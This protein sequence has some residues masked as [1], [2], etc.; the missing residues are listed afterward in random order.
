MT[1]QGG[2]RHVVLR[3]RFDTARLLPGLPAV[4]IAAAQDTRIRKP[5]GGALPVG[6][7]ALDL[8][9]AVLFSF[10]SNP[11]TYRR[12]D[13]VYRVDAHHY[14]SLASQSPLAGHPLFYRLAGIAAATARHLLGLLIHESID[15]GFA[16]SIDGLIGQSWHRPWQW[17][18]N[19]DIVDIGEYMKVAGIPAR[20][21]GDLDAELVI[22][23]WQARRTS[24]LIAPTPQLKAFSES[25]LSWSVLVALE[26]MR[27]PVPPPPVPQRD[28]AAYFESIWSRMVEEGSTGEL[29]RVLSRV[30]RLANA[31]PQVGDV[32]PASADHELVRVA[33]DVLAHLEPRA[34]D[35]E[36]AQSLAWLV[37]LAQVSRSARGD[38]ST[39]A[40][41]SAL[42]DLK[43]S[44]ET[45]RRCAAEVAESLAS[46]ERS[47]RQALV[48]LAEQR[49]LLQQRDAEI[50]KLRSRVERLSEKGA[51]VSEHVAPIM[52]RLLVAGGSQALARRLAQ[53]MPEAV[54][55]P[56]DSAATL[57]L[58]V[59]NGC[60]AVVVLTSHVSHALADK[61]SDEARRQGVPVVLVGWSNAQRIVS[62]IQQALDRSS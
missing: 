7:T 23:V 3:G 48:E 16:S 38:S 42:Q 18:A 40:A 47:R 56:E 4:Q 31:L 28:A 30:T 54:F 61:V 34:G 22:L 58:S 17:V 27:P 60:R 39:Q 24:R 8:L 43:Q 29:G 12:V 20:D 45:E 49:T 46:S 53:W 1:E 37:A 55:V 44:V 57:D 21:R 52:G 41:Q 51:V 35:A 25:L 5:A 26:S 50:A 10:A 33:S 14:G 9:P 15:Q 19:H 32:A 13:A 6:T 62:A 36:A 2:H 11:A 59:V